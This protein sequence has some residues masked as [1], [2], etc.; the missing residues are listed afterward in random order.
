MPV[1]F[2]GAWVPDIRTI[3]IPRQCEE[4]PGRTEDPRVC[5]AGRAPDWLRGESVLVGCASANECKGDRLGTL[6]QAAALRK[7]HP[8]AGPSRG[9]NHNSVASAIFVKKLSHVLVLAPRRFLGWCG[10]PLWAGSLAPSAAGYRHWTEASSGGG[11][12]RQLV[13]RFHTFVS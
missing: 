12:A 4:P 5:G 8:M 13:M 9:M 3:E 6:L 11:Q 10:C 7:R 2:W 1:P